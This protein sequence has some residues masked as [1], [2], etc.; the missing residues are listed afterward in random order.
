MS[1]HHALIKNDPR[2]HAAREEC[3]ERDGYRCV[4]CGG[5]EDLQADHVLELNELVANG[6]LDLAFEVDNLATRCGPCN[7]AKHAA[8]GTATVRTEYVSERYPTL[9]V[10]LAER[11]AA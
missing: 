3:L 5:T 10:L 7:R 2:W 9:A 6:D 1:R 11:Y 8:G 4:D